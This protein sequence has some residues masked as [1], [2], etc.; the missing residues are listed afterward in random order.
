MNS[1]NVWQVRAEQ[2]F[3]LTGGKPSGN[4]AAAIELAA[5]RGLDRY[6]AMV[7]QGTNADAAQELVIAEIRDELLGAMAGGRRHG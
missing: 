5:A 1:W 6:I 4:H 2:I 7:A 3:T